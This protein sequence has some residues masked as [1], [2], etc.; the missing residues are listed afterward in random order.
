MEMSLII[1]KAIQKII[2]RTA[3]VSFIIL[4]RAKLSG[5]IS[6]ILFK[7]KDREEEDKSAVKEYPMMASSRMTSSMEKELKS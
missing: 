6:V 3:E 1:T 7:E 5:S 4:F 2:N